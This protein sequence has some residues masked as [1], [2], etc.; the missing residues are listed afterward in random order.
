MANP[1][2]NRFTKISNELLEHVP[3]FRFNGTQLRLLLVIW[4][5]T[6]GFR[7]KEHEFTLS[8]LSEAIG[9]ARSQ[10]DREVTALIERNVLEVLSGGSG[11]PRVLRF[12]KDFD[13]WLE[14]PPKAPAKKRK[15]PP[16]PSPP[17]RGRGKKPEQY[18]ADNT[19]YRM[20]SYFHKKIV[21]MAANIDFNHSSI[22][23]ADLQKWAEDFRKLV[24]IDKV[25]DKQLIRDVIDWVTA[26]SF[27]Q[28]NVLSAKKLRE[29]FG[30]LA[31]KMKAAGVRSG[32]K[33]G[34]NKSA[35]DRIAKAQ[36]W[37][38]QG[39]DPYAFEPD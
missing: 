16:S 20:A 24:E 32:G 35:I 11:R 7:R 29:K 19:Y 39:G 28:T 21:A 25:T 37:I 34:G 26:D 13:A 9:A 3:R 8:F 14:R 23:K 27:W 17:R 1:Q 10:V 30:E 15:P 31:L 4:R 33:G 38:E 36:E 2:P 18:S 22:A 12:N 6:Y 5:Y